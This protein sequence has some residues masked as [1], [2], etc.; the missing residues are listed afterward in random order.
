MG[1]SS[2][3]TTFLPLQWV[4]EI[5]GELYG[6][7][8]LLILSLILFSAAL[9]ASIMCF[10]PPAAE[11]NTSGDYHFFYE[12]VAKNLAAGKGLVDNRGEF[13]TL[14]P[15]GF[16]V[17]LAFQFKAG[18][19]LGIEPLLIVAIL[20]VLISS[21]S[22]GCVFLIAEYVFVK[23]V[24]VLAALAWATYPANVW[25]SF[26]P[27]SEVPYF[28][29]F[30][31]AV[32]A[33]SRALNE[34]NP[35]FAI[36]AG[37]LMGLGTLVRPIALSSAFFLAGGLVLFSWKHSRPKGFAAGAILMASFLLT[38]LP[39]ELY[40]S[41]K[42]GRPL[43]MFAKGSWIMKQGV[44]SVITDASKNAVPM[45]VGRVK[46]DMLSM[47]LG[48]LKADPWPV[49]KLL[50]VKLVSG[51]YATYRTRKTI[52]MLPFQ[53]FYLFFGAIGLRLALRYDRRHLSCIWLLLLSIAGAWFTTVVTVPLLRYMIPQMGF[54]LIFCAF[55]C[56]HFL[57]GPARPS[58]PASA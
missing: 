35:K 32:F 15:P 9:Q 46:Q 7:R 14:F 40:V 28:P 24:A 48:K 19:I 5:L 57:F 3:V 30:F 17:M 4:R 37:I 25:L 18:A 51:W 27:N 21:L 54:V 55:A 20:N 45:D 50:C 52:Q 12:P 11:R 41:Q 10:L 23:R 53:L 26:Q 47:L 31:L 29:V 8:R 22:C 36:K 39:W 33:A 44:E 1:A 34:R 6:R 38:I 56:D 43:P 42:T 13:A 16:P 2:A 49:L 58:S